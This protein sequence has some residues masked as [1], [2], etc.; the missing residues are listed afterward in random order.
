MKTLSLNNSASVA[1]IRPA[2]RAITERFT[3]IIH[4]DSGGQVLKKH[5]LALVLLIAPA[6]WAQTITVNASTPIRT[7]P[8]T[9]YGGNL[10]AWDGT[11]DGNN[12]K[13]NALMK[14]SGRKY[15]RIIGGSWSNGHL[16][17]DIEELNSPFGSAAW[18]VSYQE[19]LNLLTA[20]NE[21]G[22]TTPPTFQPIVNFPGIWYQDVNGNAIA[23]GHQAAVDA[24]VDWVLDQ[25]GRSVTAQYWEIGNEVYG[26][27][28]AGWFSGINGTYYGDYYAD[29]HLGMKEANPNIKIGAVAYEADVNGLYDWYTG[30]WTYDLLRAAFAKGVV[31]DYLI[32]HQ[33]PGSGQPAS[34]NSTLLST[35][36]NNIGVF[37]SQLN[38]MVT[39]AIGSQYVGQVKYAMTEWDAGDLESPLYQRTRA[40]INAMFHTQYILEMCKNNW[41]V[42]NAW[43]PAELDNSN[44]R[45]NPVWWAHPLLVHYFG[46]DMVQASSSDADV[47]AY[48][49]KDATGALTLFMVN[50]SSTVSK[51]ASI[52]ISGFTGSTS[53]QRW[54]IAPAGVTVAGG[55]SNARDN[56]DLSINGVASPSPLVAPSFPAQSV[57]TG[58]SFSVTL[59]AN[60]M[61]LIRIPPPS[62]DVTPPPVPTGLV[63]TA[64]YRTV[65]LNWNDVSASDLKGY[66]VYRGTTSG[67]LVPVALAT[68]S[69]YTDNDVVNGTTYYYSVTAVDQTFNASASSGQVLATP[70]APPQG[71][72]GGTAWAIPGV[73]EAENYDVGGEG[74]AYHDL[75]VGN[76]GGQYR[77]EDDVDVEACT[78]TGGGFNVGWADTGEWLEYTVNVAATGSYNI[79]VRAASATT[80]STFSIQVDGVTVAGPLSVPN[81][82][83]WQTWTNVTASGINLTAG[84]RVVRVTFDG[85]AWNFNKMTFSSGGGG[86]TPTA[87]SSLAASAVSANQINLTWADNSSNEVTF[88]LLRATNSAFTANVVTTTLGANATNTSATGLAA[89]TTYY[90]RVRATNASGAS[91]YSNT[92]SARTK[93]R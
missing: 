40:Y 85:S 57:L 91:V 45:V 30:R 8:M 39:D 24:A 21:S 82:G 5:L 75:T 22:Q 54:L 83:S 16:W 11:Q 68:T 61:M 51:T 67:N 7:I 38:A 23:H 78:D 86:G 89:R 72:F 70:S 41:V 14:A 28:E 71:P 81:T 34:Y 90:F 13:F 48:A 62:G 19:F 27:W 20:L 42:S 4:L 18:K 31:P 92:A 35:D 55:S 15:Q 87:P 17:S 44:W 64:G 50:N 47:R 93:N 53:G 29:F 33:Y 63:A 84:Q 52:M 26:P 69:D 9:M 88:E 25:S 37:T 66:R 32:I 49:A 56:N 43:T 76:S 2:G 73:I 1:Q 77:T 74:F 10:Q 80:G 12:A 65:A 46:R 60:N 36:V 59:P 79:V 6:A 3:S 58:S